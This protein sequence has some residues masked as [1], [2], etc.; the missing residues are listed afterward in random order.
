MTNND[1]DEYG[2]Y[3]DPGHQGPGPELMG[4]DTLIGGLGDDRY[5]VD[6]TADADWVGSFHEGRDE[7]HVMLGQ[8]SETLG[9][10]VDSE[11]TLHFAASSPV[12]TVYAAGIVNPL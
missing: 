4:A 9:L 7:V 8:G 11:T 10:Y 5:Y 3:T 2:N 6:N 12:R 1:L